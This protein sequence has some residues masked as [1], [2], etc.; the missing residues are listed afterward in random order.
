[1]TTY[2]ACSTA[3]GPAG[4]AVIRVSGPAAAAT[5]AAMTAQPL[6][7]AR[8]AALRRLIDPQN[9]TLLDQALVLY[10]AAPSS[11]TGEDVVECHVHGS[12]A[13]VSAVLA[14]LAKQS[15]LV[16]APPGAFTR[17]AFDNGKLDLAEV[18]GLADLV[19]AETEAQRQQALQ[20][21]GGGL[22]RQYEA[23]RHELIH[24]LALLEAEIDF[25]EG[26]DDVPA[27][28]AGAVGG[29]VAALASDIRHHLDDGQIGEKIRD[30][31]TMAIIGA[32]NVGKS[33][34][35][36]ALAK[37]DVAIVSST[38]GTTR[39]A[40]E[41]GLNLAGYAVTLI[42]TAGL[43]DTDDAIEAE[44]VRRA[45]LRAAAADL[46][47]EVITPNGTIQHKTGNGICIV[48][49]IDGHA[50]PSGLHNGALHISVK[51]GDGLP[52]LINYLAEWATSRLDSA[53][54]PIIT[55]HRHR[56]LL[57]SCAAH[58]EAAT[59]QTNDSVLAAESLRLAARSLGQITG[60]VDV[61]D[62][63]D[64]IFSSFCIGK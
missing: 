13:V 24:A 29:T 60:R 44:G 61:E 16:A 35:L 37:R 43:R 36:N 19:S 49:K 34:L 23:W 7:P 52:A 48:N 38:P 42:D 6:P 53:E 5:L 9:G 3:R 28:I 20:Q 59:I 18:E 33:S 1:M 31:L 32:P 12:A 14:V 27:G 58:L 45:R 10:F 17:Q 21:M 62:V 41:V 40:I 46:I 15:G 55:R 30:G 2:Y 39:D 63:L 8:Q 54:A 26:E 11:F 64:V 22:S 57:E 47:L 50:L 51:T 56:Q 25:A 4:V